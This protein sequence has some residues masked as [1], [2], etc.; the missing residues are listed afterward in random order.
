M[1]DIERDVRFN[2]LRLIEKGRKCIKSYGE[3]S[4][5]DRIHDYT[6]GEKAKGKVLGR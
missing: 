5:I 1:K 4:R 2:G 6:F 3:G